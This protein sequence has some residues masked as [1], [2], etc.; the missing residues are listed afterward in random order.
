MW[1]PVTLP[2]TSHSE[3]SP[4][5][6]GSLSSLWSEP[7]LRAGPPALFFLSSRAHGLLLPQAPQHS[8]E[9]LPP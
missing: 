9:W 3:T 1:E 7:L 8:K 4:L 2:G 5:H 6:S